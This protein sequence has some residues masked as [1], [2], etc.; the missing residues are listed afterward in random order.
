MFLGGHFCA[1]PLAETVG[2][3]Y[4]RQ[5]FARPHLGRYIQ[6]PLRLKGSLVEVAVVAVAVGG[7][8]RTNVAGE[9]TAAG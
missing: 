4:C 7:G 5:S 8:L 3:V 1:G 6:T 2:A 9:G